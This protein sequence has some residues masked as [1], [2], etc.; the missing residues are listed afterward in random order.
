[1]SQ[2]ITT[3]L[4]ALVTLGAAICYAV[5]PAKDPQGMNKK[6]RKRLQQILLAS[7]ILLV[8][9]FIST[10]TF[11][12]VDAFTFPTAGRWLRLI[13]YLAGY[14]IIGRDILRKAGKGIRNGQIMDEC[15]LMA[16]ATLGALAL[17]VYEN[18]E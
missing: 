18:G 16:V 14:W 9:Q 7:A 17:A 4:F 8:L 3:A 5:L 13:A 12:R 15:F 6:Q 10:D 11:N 2:I 1:M